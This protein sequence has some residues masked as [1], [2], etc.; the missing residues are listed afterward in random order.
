VIPVDLY[1]EIFPALQVADLD[2]VDGAAGPGRRLVVW[3]QGCLK[4]CP[5][6]ANG[7]FLPR[8]AARILTVA[9]LTQALE[10]A[11]N[12]DGVTLSGGEPVLQAAALL[13]WLRE[14]RR[15]GFTVVCY[16]GYEIEELR[17]ADPVLTEFL[18]EV[19]L[20]IDGE[21]R[22]E[23]P[24]GGTYRPSANQRLHFLSGR[25]AP[26]SCAA[27]VETVFRLDGGRLFATGTLPEAVRRAIVEELQQRGVLVE[28]M[29]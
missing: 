8:A 21:Y 14:V 19:D 17:T 28:P 10:A 12:V 2:V 29:P 26:E 16:T 5:G 27:P 24:R 18:A 22:R 20:L 13:P 11:G 3:L 23:L 4:R 9:D 25:I 1:P 6:C 15:R 7:P